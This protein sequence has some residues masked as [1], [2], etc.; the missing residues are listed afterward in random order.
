MLR[1]VSVCAIAGAACAAQGAT[2]AEWTFEV[3]IPMTA[4]PHMAE[5]GVFAATSF[6]SGS[7]ANPSTVYSNPAGNG[8][9]ESFSSNFWT[10]GD[11]YQFQTSALGYDTIT[12]TWDQA[13]SS[14]GPTPFDLLWSSDGVNFTTLLDD[15]TVIVNTTPPG[16]WNSTTTF[17][18]YR[19]GPIAVPGAD[20]AAVLYFRLVSQVTPANT[21]GTNRV[22]NV[23]IE[24]NLIPSPGSLAL[25]GLGSLFVLRRGRR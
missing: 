9:P 3:S 1:V 14:T 10:A 19:F 11:Y 23:R 7:H 20:N 4:G 12:I 18:D 17:L 15:Y 16:A 5:G 22:D 25:L 6:A 21:A 13:R 24:G 8:S 2:L